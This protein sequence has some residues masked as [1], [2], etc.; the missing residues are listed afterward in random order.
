M[1]VGFAKRRGYLGIRL[2]AKDAD[3]RRW[4]ENIKR[5]GMATTHTWLRRVG[6]MHKKFGEASSQMASLKPKEATSFVLDV[7]GTLEKDGLSG[8]YVAGIIQPVTIWLDFNGIP[9]Q[10]R[11]K[12]HGRNDWYGLLTRDGPTLTSSIQNWMGG[13]QSDNHLV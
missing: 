10:Q 8:S 2:S 7:I 11:L 4:Y 1:S 6:F 13:Y 12:I 5:G 9:V 3:F